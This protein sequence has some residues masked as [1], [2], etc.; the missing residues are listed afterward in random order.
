[1][2]KISREQYELN[3]ETTYQCIKEFIEKNGYSPSMREIADNTKRS[4][5]T[6]FNHVYELKEQG[7]IDFA[8][9]KARTIRLK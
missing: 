6:I 7:K 5:D 8:E 3:L 1:M 2:A 4:L 9:G